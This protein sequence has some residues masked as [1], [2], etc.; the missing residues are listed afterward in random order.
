VLELVTTDA[1]GY[2]VA[3]NNTIEVERGAELRI[4]A[5]DRLRRPLKLSGGTLTV[6]RSGSVHAL[7][8]YNAPSFTVT[9]DSVLTN[10]NAA[11]TLGFVGQDATI[12]LQNNA[13]L[14]CYVPFANGI[15]D[16]D[17]NN[18]TIAGSGTFVQ[19]ALMIQF[20]NKV[21]VA[22]G[23]TFRQNAVTAGTVGKSSWDVNG[24]LEAN[25]I[26]QVNALTLASGA[27][28]SVKVT[29]ANVS[30]AAILCDVTP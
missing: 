4:D 1:T 17:S 25:A 3:A 26:M 14:D 6:S 18:V 13:T 15:M 20:T 8:L 27:T 5:G 12:S 16:G 29:D 24:T 9:A 11:A 2:D 23:V 30:N 10:G 21:T 22:N 19:N 28:L 7:A